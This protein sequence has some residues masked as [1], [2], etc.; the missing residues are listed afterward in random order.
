MKR[1]VRICGLGVKVGLPETK[2]TGT[3]PPVRYAFHCLDAISLPKLDV[4]DDEVGRGRIRFPYRVGLGID[5]RADIMPHILYDDPK[6]QRHQRLVFHDH[7]LGLL[8]RFQWI[9]VQLTGLYRHGAG[10]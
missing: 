7:D 4:R 1:T 8:A 10:T 3:A 6:L 9:R 5:D 2:I